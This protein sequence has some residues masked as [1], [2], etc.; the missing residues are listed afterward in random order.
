M[1]VNEGGKRGRVENVRSADG[2]YRVPYA[3]PGSIEVRKTITQD[4]APWSSFVQFA[5]LF[6]ALR[7]AGH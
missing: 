7:K 1:G 3:G 5:D 4:G 6:A 2:V